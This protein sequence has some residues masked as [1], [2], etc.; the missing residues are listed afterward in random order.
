M[1]V[2]M[3]GK[4][5]FFKTIDVKQEVRNSNFK[6]VPAGVILQ[7]AALMLMRDSADSTSRMPGY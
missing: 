6:P 3:N 4:A 1:D 7:Q 2:N 5:L